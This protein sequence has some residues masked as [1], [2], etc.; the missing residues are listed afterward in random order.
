MPS[1]ME[2]VQ[3]KPSAEISGGA[4]AKSGRASAPP[5]S[6]GLPSN[7]MSVR[8]RQH[9]KISHGSASYSLWKSSAAWK[10]SAPDMVR[11]KVPPR[12]GPIVSE[13]CGSPHVHAA[14][15][16]ESKHAIEETLFK[17]T[18]QSRKC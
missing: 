17:G 10:S 1:R 6:A 4:E 18:T 3:T 2:N 5:S 13:G 9:R 15:R 14:T 7:D 16:R 12:G 8:R 11:C